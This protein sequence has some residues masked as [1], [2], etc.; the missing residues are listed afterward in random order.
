ML[1][2][3]YIYIYTWSYQPAYLLHDCCCLSQSN[4]YV[5]AQALSNA[6]IDAARCVSKHCSILHSVSSLGRCTCATAVYLWH[7]WDINLSYEYKCLLLPQRKESRSCRQL[8]KIQMKLSKCTN[9]QT[10]TNARMRTETQA[11]KM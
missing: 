8:M 11:S 10:Q 7:L 4:K 5:Y 9:K 2:N 1:I 3:M 6:K